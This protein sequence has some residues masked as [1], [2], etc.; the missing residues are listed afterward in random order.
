MISVYPLR[1]LMRFI[2]EFDEKDD[3][4]I[5]SA[6]NNK[7]EMLALY[8]IERLLPFTSIHSLLH[9]H[10]VCSSNLPKNAIVRVNHLVE[11]SEKRTFSGREQSWDSLIWKGGL[12]R[13]LSRQ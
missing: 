3:R 7:I 10:Y 4:G 2:V 9:A 12:S 13:F 6:A 11:H 8:A 5:G 1:L